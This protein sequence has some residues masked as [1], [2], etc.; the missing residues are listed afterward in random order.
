MDDDIRN[1]SEKVSK[2]DEEECNGEVFMPSIFDEREDFV[3]VEGD[4]E[5]SYND[6]YLQKRINPVEP[7]WGAEV[8]QH[9]LRK[10]CFS[11]IKIMNFYYILPFCNI[12][13]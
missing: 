13:S 6:Y 12:S 10:N 7:G 8:H 4:Y 3:A 11:F 2:S 5:R 1:D 9:H